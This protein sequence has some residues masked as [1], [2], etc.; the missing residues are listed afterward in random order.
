MPC[1]PTYAIDRRFPKVLAAGRE[2][3]PRSMVQL[4]EQQSSV[5]EYNLDEYNPA[6]P[7]VVGA[8]KDWIM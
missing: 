8:N 6:G 5:I 4:I 7:L 3:L 2:G 1:C